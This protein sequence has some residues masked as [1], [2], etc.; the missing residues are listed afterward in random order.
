MSA[1]TATPTRTTSVAPARPSRGEILAYIAVACA[2][3]WAVAAPA[4][5]GAVQADITP[6]LVPL[7]QLTPVLATVPFFLRR[8][9]GRPRDLL[10][11]RWNRSG[12]WALVGIALLAAIGGLQ[13]A[14]GLALGWELRAADLV[15][16]AAVAVIPVLALQAVFAIGEETGWR[17]WLVS[18]TRHLGFPAMAVISSVAW[19]V[20][21]IPALALLPQGAIAE[22]A[23]YLLGIAA[24]APFLV[25]LRLA[26]GSVWPAVFVHGAINSMRVFLLQSVADSH[27]ID[28]IVEAAGWAL[29]II[30]AALLARRTVDAGSAA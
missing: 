7:A 27:G 2:L 12:R 3:C 24:M 9:P 6:A 15:Q 26:S 8:R 14:L 1:P 11:L 4:L 17:G 20:W 25:A 28:W 29:W 19:T 5:L 21:H 16:S 30:A 22:S 23:A 18:R 10:A 13:L